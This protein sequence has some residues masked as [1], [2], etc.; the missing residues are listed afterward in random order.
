MAMSAGRVGATRHDI[1]HHYD[2]GTPFFGL[3]LD[4]TLT[5][6]C[7]AWEDA[8]TL[9]DAQRRKLRQHLA[10][11]SLPAEARLLDIG[12]G[13]GSA[14][15]LAIDEGWAAE[16]HGLTLSNDQ[17]AHVAA[18]G[19]DRVGAEV[20]HW[21]DFTAPHRF[22][23]ALC[24]ETIEH[25][26]GRSLR[27]R[28]RVGVY[29]DFFARVASWLAPGARLSLQATAVGHA[30]L[31]RTTRRDIRFLLDEVF[32]GSQLPRP[33]DLVAAAPPSFEVEELTAERRRY[34]RTCGT[35][36]ARL[37]EGRAEA[38]AMVGAPVVDR[39]ERYLAAS[40]RMFERGH[41][42]LVRLRLRR[43]SPDQR[44]SDP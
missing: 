15:R 10:A 21:R 31:D 22:D 13:W 39:F 16:A 27:R 11:L 6:S 26:A 41:I 36:L 14:L 44:S 9:A 5:Y 28:E 2:V 1:E 23:G 7:A 32:P 25:F 30:R 35:W 24:I 40:Q 34:V 19:D 33:A 29:G 4:E 38:E 3:F 37:R 17:A 42:T 18:L 43:P 8:D 20:V 12:C